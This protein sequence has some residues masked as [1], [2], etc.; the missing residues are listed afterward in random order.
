MEELL[1]FFKSKGNAIQITLDIGKMPTVHAFH[2]E[3]YGKRELYKTEDNTVLGALEKMKEK[4]Y[5]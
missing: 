4:L 1:K 3:E 2:E 5:G